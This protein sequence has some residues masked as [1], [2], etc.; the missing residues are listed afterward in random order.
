MSLQ[1]EFERKLDE[2]W[3][4]RTASLRREF[5]PHPRGK[6][7]TFNKTVRNRLLNELLDITTEI[8]LRETTIRAEYEEGFRQRKFIQI[9]GRGFEKKFTRVFDFARDVAGERPFVYIFWR[10]RQCLYVG[11]AGTFRRLRAYRKSY[12]LIRATR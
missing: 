6:Q 2:L 11:Q 10:Q 12:Y 4:R 7:L 9:Q 1:R 8:V 3:E 5:L